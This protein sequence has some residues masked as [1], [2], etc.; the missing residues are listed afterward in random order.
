MTTATRPRVRDALSQ[1][2]PDRLTSD[3]R[4]TSDR[5]PKPYVGILFTL[6]AM[7]LLFALIVLAAALTSMQ[8][9]GIP[10]W[11]E[12]PPQNWLIV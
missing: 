10:I 8:I 6:L 4:L 7:A 5:Q 2:R 3:K 1:V 11:Q 9:P 12:V